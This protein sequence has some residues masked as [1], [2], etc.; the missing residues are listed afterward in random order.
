[1]K[2]AFFPHFDSFQNMKVW[3]ICCSLVL[4]ASFLS[5]SA[6][7]I[8]DDLKTTIAK[9]GNPEGTIELRDKTLLLFPMGEVVLKQDLVVEID[10]MSEAEFKAEQARLQAQREEWRIEEAMRREALQK[11][12]Q[13]ILADKRSSL[14][15]AALPAKDRVDYWRG[16]QMRYPGVDVS[17]E[18]ARALE[19]YDIELAEMKSQ[20]RIAQLEARVA[21]AEQEAASARL[22]TE[23]LKAE[24]ERTRQ[25]TQYGL[26]YYHDPIVRPRYIYR[27]PTVT[28]FSKGKTHCDE[29]KRDIRPDYWK[30]RDYNPDSTAARVARILHERKSN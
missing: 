19:S 17:D 29:P 8:G 30:F 25:D 27:P 16:F 3:V 12:G 11:E 6:V 2:F 21:R 20:E 9:L 4:A 7:A 5:A 22:E 23:R 28:I 26:R 18:L 14:S 15:F 1:M 13:A 10:L 24:T